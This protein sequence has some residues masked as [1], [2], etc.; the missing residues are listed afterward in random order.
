MYLNGHK[1]LH[2]LPTGRDEDGNLK[3]IDFSYMN[4][5]DTLIRPFNAMLNSIRRRSLNKESLMKS[6]GEGMIESSS[7]TFKTLCNRI[8]FYRSFN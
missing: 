5:Y 4:A 3:Y 8:Y 2:L 7:R 6:L 1:I